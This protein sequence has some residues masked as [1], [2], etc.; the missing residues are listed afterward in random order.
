[1]THF[2]KCISKFKKNDQAVTQLEVET[3]IITEPQFITEAFAHH[4]PLFLT[5]LV[6]KKLRTT[7][8]TLVMIFLN[9]PYIYYSD[10]K[11]A[12]SHLRSTKSVGPHEILNFAIKG[13]SDIFIPLLRH[14]FNLSLFTGN[15]PSLWKQAAVVPI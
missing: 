14:I 7:L 5:L 4:F 13:C 11:R 9:V 8:T 3:K 6:V 1:M 2:W 10:V 15:F 12:I